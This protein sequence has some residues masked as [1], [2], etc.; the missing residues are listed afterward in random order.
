MTSLTTHCSNCNKWFEWDDCCLKVEYSKPARW[1]CQKCS[2]IHRADRISG[3]FGFE[4][5]QYELQD[6]MA[7]I[8]HYCDI[9]QMDFPEALR[10]A[11]NRFNEEKEATR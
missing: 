4:P 9:H 11:T 8:M 3:K 7:D 5:D 10:F 2:N 1:Y 6:L